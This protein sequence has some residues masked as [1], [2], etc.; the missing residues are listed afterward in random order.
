M[1]KGQTLLRGKMGVIKVD[2]A[3]VCELGR[4]GPVNIV[5]REEVEGALRGM[6]NGKAARPSGMT[7]D[8]FKFAG[9]TGVREL[10]RVFQGIM[11]GEHAPDE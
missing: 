7:S 4:K 11:G 9:V 1:W 5:T 3:E 10:L 8:L 6:K 2:G